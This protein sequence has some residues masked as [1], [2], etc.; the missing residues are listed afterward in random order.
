MEHGPA[1]QVGPPAIRHLHAEDDPS[2]GGGFVAVRRPGDGL[3][4]R[5]VDRVGVV[6][7]WQ[8][9]RGGRGVWAG[10]FVVVMAAGAVVMVSV[11]VVM[12]VVVAVRHRAR[13]DV[14]TQAMPGGVFSPWLWPRPAHCVS[15][16]AGIR[17]RHATRFM[18]FRSSTPTPHED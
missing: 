8:A 6:V 15:R 13:V 12:P 1:R 5:E 11:A 7:R 14:R 9:R 18:T 10:G 2:R 4:R 3:D 17:I 16:T